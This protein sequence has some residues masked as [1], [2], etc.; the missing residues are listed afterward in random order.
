MEKITLSATELME[1]AV[2]TA[3][4]YMLGAVRMIDKEFG[5]GYA[6]MHPELVGAFMRTAAEDFKTST[7]CAAIQ[8]VEKA[9][10]KLADSMNTDES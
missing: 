1:Q 2:N 6:D 8:D 7:L 9:V 3:H 5:K 10:T 4:S